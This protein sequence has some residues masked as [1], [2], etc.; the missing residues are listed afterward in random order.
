MAMITIDPG[1]NRDMKSI[2]GKVL[3]ICLSAA[4][5][6]FLWQ[7]HEELVKFFDNLYYIIGAIFGLCIVG[8]WLSSGGANAIKYAVYAFAQ[9]FLG[10]VIE[11]NPFSILNYRLEKMKESIDGLLKD[12]KVLEAKDSELDDKMSIAD[13]ELS[14]AISTKNILERKGI[15][16][17]TENEED[18]YQMALQV[19]ATNTDYINGIK[20]VSNDIKRL[21]DFTK[22]ANRA[23]TLELK[24]SKADLDKKRDLYETV[25]TASST[26]SRAWKA[27]MGDE[28]LNSDAD[29]AIAFLRKDISAKIG[30]MKVGLKATTQFM[31]GK[32][33]ENSAKLQS[34]LK[35]L[36]PVAKQLE[37]GVRFSSTVD[38]KETKIE[39]AN[40]GKTNYNKFINP[41]K[42][43]DKK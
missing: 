18:N 22:R 27:L 39:M 28:S 1:G 25:T 37:E 7:N 19:I 11:M 13:N 34:A 23:S 6:Y 31:D 33:L 3:L 10:W 38:S 20:P 21:I 41:P 2:V 8:W 9:F 16:N 36:E 15:N 4:L 35:Q 17:L 29:K 43:G 12:Q 24:K 26:V 40:L 42:L 32:D 5:V 30:A 14:T